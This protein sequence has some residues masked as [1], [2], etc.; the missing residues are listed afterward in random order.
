MSP[1]QQ[2]HIEALLAAGD[3]DGAE[4]ALAAAPAGPLADYLRGRLAWRRGDKAAAMAAYEKAAAADPAGPG[5]I[6]LEQLRDIMAFYHRDL[7]N[8]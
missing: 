8:P 6:A 4:Q 7:Y 1:E 5:A 3:L 2:A